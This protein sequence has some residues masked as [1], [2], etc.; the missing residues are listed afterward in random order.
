MTTPRRVRN[1]VIVRRF[2][3][4]RSIGE[5]AFEFNVD[6]ARIEQAI[7]DAMNRRSR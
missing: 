4:G 6:H 3:A 1:D 5:I 7:R 2:L